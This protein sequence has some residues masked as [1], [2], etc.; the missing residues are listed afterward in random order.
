MSKYIYIAIITIFISACASKKYLDS[1]KLSLGMTRSEV[2][3]VFG[4]PDR[5]LHAQIEGRQLIE[6]VEYTD[7]QNGLY[8]LIFENHKLVEYKL[9]DNKRETHHHNIPRKK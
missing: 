8:K 9:S 5:V 7:P 3:K 6:T 1:S 2:E 4:K